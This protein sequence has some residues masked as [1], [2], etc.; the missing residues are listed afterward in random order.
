MTAPMEIQHSQNMNSTS[1]LHHQK[2]LT[3]KTVHSNTHYVNVTGKSVN[4]QPNK[5]NKSAKQSIR[6]N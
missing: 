2:G 5:S 1:L 4:K 6:L 3:I